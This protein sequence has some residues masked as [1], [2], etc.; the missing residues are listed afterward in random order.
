M[1]IK[2]LK[3]KNYRME[4]MRNNEWVALSEK[5]KLENKSNKEWEDSKDMAI[6]TILLCLASS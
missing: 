2:A 1:T 4:K 5:D 6:Y 3:V